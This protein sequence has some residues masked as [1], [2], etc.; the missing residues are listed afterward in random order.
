MVTLPLRFVPVLLAALAACA[1]AAPPAV[2][3]TQPGDTFTYAGN[4]LIRDRHTADPAPLVVGGRLYL[5]VGHD[6]ARGDQMFNITQWLAYSTTDMRT[7]TYHGPVMRPTDFAWAARDA[8]ASQVIEKDGRFWFYT[9]VEHDPAQG[10]SGKAV[11]VAMADNPLGPFTDAR[12]SAL[13]R[14]EDTQGPHSW[15]DIDPT[16]W[17]EADGTTWLFW[18]NAELKMAPLA[19]DMTHLAGPIRTIELPDFEE[20]PWIFERQGTY[21]L[22]YASMDKAIHPDERISYATALAIT[23]P[24]TWR[25]QITGAAANSFTIH[26]GVVEFQGEW[27]LFY[28]VGTLDVGDQP[29]GLGRRA[30]AVERLRFGPDGAILPVEQTARGILSLP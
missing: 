8:W 15:D 7:W 27:Y 26:P 23:G 14:N 1:P 30:V 24:W 28:H 25:G 4:P 11:G 18:G 2:M 12:G 17:T 6:E 13:I 5:Y 29:G 20:G 16:V 21:Y 19:T 3:L 9:T 10:S 22:A